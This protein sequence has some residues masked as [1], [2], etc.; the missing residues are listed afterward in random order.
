MKKNKPLLVALLIIAA[1][2][3]AYF[4]FFRK[5]ETSAELVHQVKKG[6]FEVMITTSGE[7]RSKSNTRIMA[8]PELQQVGVYQIKISDMV[9][10]GSTVKEGEFVAS[11]DNSSLMDKMNQQRIEIEKMNAQI[12]QA[13]LDTMLEMRGLRD[14]IQNLEY[15]LKQK[16]LEKEQSRFEA[17]AEI[18]RVQLDYEK[19]ERTLKQ[20]KENYKTKQ[21]QAQT[22][23]QIY[24]SDMAQLMNR[25]E[26]LMRL[27]Q[28]LNITAPK[29]G[30]VTYEKNWN[31]QKKSVG[32]QIDMWNPTVATL[33]DLTQ[34]EVFTYVNEVDVQR[35]RVG[36][37][38]SIALD[39]SPDKK[40]D[41]VVKSVANIGE[42]RP[43]SDAKVFEV[44][45]DVTTKDDE[46]R[47][48]MTVSCKILTEK[49]KDVVQVP[50]ESIFS[51]SAKSF[52]YTRKDGALQKQQVVVHSSNETAA[53]ISNGLTGGETIFLSLPAD[54]AGLAFKA[55]DTKKTIKPAQLI[56][57]D[58]S[59]IKQMKEMAAKEAKQTGP[60][61]SGMIIIESE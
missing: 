39:A 29:G 36:Q 23:L 51:E 59:L 34:M 9:A 27:M 52:V 55:I 35:V 26:R 43:N 17:P 44:L 61:S 1:A 12:K 11:L 58:S 57:L 40:L 25:N 37:K 54:T 50:L 47:P 4:L 41:G 48:A 15:D 13:T 5:K 31:G 6:D 60:V 16:V 42:E 56:T 33:P 21:I 22:K 8:P 19:T 45:I 28:Q 10:E 24:G 30:M 38:V 14:E 46:L 2:V 32:S 20:K 49:Y 7:L 53:I 18:N 3:L